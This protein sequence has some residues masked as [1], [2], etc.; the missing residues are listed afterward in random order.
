MSSRQN[1][2]FRSYSTRAGR[3]PCLQDRLHGP[4]YVFSSD[5]DLTCPLFEFS[6]RRKTVAAGVF[7]RGQARRGLLA[8]SWGSGGTGVAPGSPR[9][10]GPQFSCP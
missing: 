6:C 8:E 2:W 1:L 10:S 4:A 5:P 7:E 3:H 9:P